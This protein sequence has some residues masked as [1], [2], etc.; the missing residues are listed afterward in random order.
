MNGKEPNK[1]NPPLSRIFLANFIALLFVAGVCAQTPAIVEQ[2]EPARPAT[3][4]VAVQ[5]RIE[6]A[7]ALAAAHQLAAAASELEAVRR[8]AQDDVLRNITSVML[9]GIYLEDANYLR[10]ESLLEEDFRGRATGSDAALRTYF[11]TAGQALNGARSHLARYR[12]FGIN[13]TDSEL[14]AEATNDLERL[15]RLLERMVAQAKEVVSQRKAYDSLSLLEDVLAVRLSVAT[16]GEDRAK[17]ETEYANAREVLASSQSQIASLSGAP[18]LQRVASEQTRVPTPT[19]KEP[20]ATTTEPQPAATN[21]PAVESPA[22][23]KKPE[24]ATASTGS[25]NTRATKRVVPTYPPFAKSAG[26][27]GVVRVYVTIDE[28]GK[29]IEVRSVDGPMV[30]RQSASD[31]ARNWRFT[32]TVKDG[33]TVRLSGFIEFTF[34][35]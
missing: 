23:E 4:S 12:S 32:P 22:E 19:V 18:S 14:P 27:E 3:E 15:R 5:T 24:P 31:A 13:V 17:W 6:R 9:M 26:I 8:M 20:P 28:G 1:I 11:A 10:A 34:T 30:L 7:R 2:P 21:A 29:V 25:L 16:D 33:K 35:L